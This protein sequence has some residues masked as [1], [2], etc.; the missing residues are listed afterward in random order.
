MVLNRAWIT[1]PIID[2]LS[3]NGTTN[4]IGDYSLE[5]II[6]RYTAPYDMLISHINIVV[7][8][9]GKMDSGKYGNNITLTN[10]IKCQLEND[11]GE[12]TASLINGGLIYTN[13]DYA[14]YA[15]ELKLVNWGSGN[16]I[17]VVHFEFYNQWGTPIYLAKGHSL[18]AI[19]NDDFTGLVSHEFSLRGKKV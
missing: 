18:I 16:E 13:A 8:D 2:H 7:E 14:R 3:N 11:R 15:E 12:M 19:L 6:A 10:G 4:F 9:V 17:M 5:P 1:R